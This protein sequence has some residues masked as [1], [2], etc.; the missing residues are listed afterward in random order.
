MDVVGHGVEHGLRWWPSIL[1]FRAVCACGDF[2][3]CMRMRSRPDVA[4]WVVDERWQVPYADEVLGRE[5]V[6]P[7]PEI[8]H[9]DPEIVARLHAEG[10]ARLPARVEGYHAEIAAINKFARERGVP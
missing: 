10:E 8:V 6:H 1:A 4:P 2:Y 5:Y 9:P 7:D 3:P